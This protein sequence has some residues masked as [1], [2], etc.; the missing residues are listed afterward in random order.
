ML[1]V[2]A[3]GRLLLLAHSIAMLTCLSLN[4]YCNRSHYARR[5]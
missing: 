5:L 1:S 2:G 4:M 3:N